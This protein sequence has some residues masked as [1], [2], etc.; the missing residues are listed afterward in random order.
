MSSLINKS[1]CKK[2]IVELTK[3]TRPRFTRISDE[4]FT[5]LEAQ[6]KIYIAKSIQNHPSKGKTLKYLNYQ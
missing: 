4:Y 2:Y 6:L 3:A 5:A 1:A